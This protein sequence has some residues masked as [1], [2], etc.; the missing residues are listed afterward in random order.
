MKL[1]AKRVSDG[2]FSIRS[3]LIYAKPCVRCW[4]GLGG[5][6]GGGVA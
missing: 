6:G 3:E 1:S 2:F 5:E 4:V